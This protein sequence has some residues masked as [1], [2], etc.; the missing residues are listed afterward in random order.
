M[1]AMIRAAASARA[2]QTAARAGI[3]NLDRLRRTNDLESEAPS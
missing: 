2:I 3:E 1:F